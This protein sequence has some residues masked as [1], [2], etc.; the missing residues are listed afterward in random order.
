MPL[1]LSTGKTYVG[2]QAIKLL[3]A[4]TCNRQGSTA[5]RTAVG[6]RMRRM[7]PPPPPPPPTHPQQSEP[8]AKPDVGPI[9]LVCYTNHAVDSLMEGVLDAGVATKR[10]EMVR[11]GGGSKS[12]RLQAINLKEV[13]AIWTL[14]TVCR[15]EKG[16]CAQPQDSPAEGYLQ[17]A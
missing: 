14:L 12:E 13:R 8:S 6:P 2:V 5:D 1:C 15:F 17:A 11:V 10:G 16:V 7:R 3:I 9:L 4:N